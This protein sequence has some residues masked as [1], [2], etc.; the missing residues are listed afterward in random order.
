MDNERISPC[1]NGKEE[2][3]IQNEI[4]TEDSQSYRRAVNRTHWAR[5]PTPDMTNAPSRA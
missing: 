5:V 1:S 2:K 3:L 4:Q